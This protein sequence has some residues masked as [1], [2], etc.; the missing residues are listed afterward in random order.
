MKIHR[1]RFQIGY[2]FT[3][4]RSAIAIA[5]KETLDA[6]AMLERF[7]A[8]DMERKERKLANV[9]SLAPGFTGDNAILQPTPVSGAANR[10]RSSQSVESDGGLLL[11]AK[12][13]FDEHSKP[14]D[15]SSTPQRSSRLDFAEFE[16]GLAPPDPWDT[17]R[18][19]DDDLRALTEVM[20]LSSNS[21]SPQ[22]PQ[23]RGTSSSV[24]QT[25]PSS[26]PS[27]HHVT[28]ATNADT[29]NINQSSPL[30]HAPGEMHH[31]PAPPPKPAALTAP[32]SLFG[33]SF[34]LSS[35]TA[36]YP[37]LDGQVSTGASLPPADPPST[38][39]G[40]PESLLSIG[41]R[42]GRIVIPQTAPIN[43]AEE[44]AHLLLSP[45]QERYTAMGFS[46]SG[47]NH[48]I[49]RFS[50]DESKYLDY[51]V[52]H[53][54]LAS[55]AAHTSEDVDLALASLA[56]PQVSMDSVRSFLAALKTLSEMGFERQK[57]SEA[58]LLN[59]T[60]VDRAAAFLMRE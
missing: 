9:R 57:I 35:T 6:A 60:D 47:V 53:D 21:F 42:A 2:D 33:S 52:A 11:Y 40:A 39:E 22:A 50:K 8:L 29:S 41:Q 32:D 12:P 4:E 55:G 49:K 3:V 30:P 44:P 10:K 46:L 17:P 34:I 13:Q 43:S 45:L 25:P 16:G 19:R 36:L 15:S 14:L 1:S 27:I 48:A 37:S 26:S 23:A 7:K 18:S 51:L 28:L 59:G 5:E 54:Q 38:A 58:L 31:A 20:G 56:Y 24:S